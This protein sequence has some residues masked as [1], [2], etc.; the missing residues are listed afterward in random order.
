MRR[1]APVACL[2]ALFAVPLIGVTGCGGAGGSV[3]VVR[4]GDQAISKASVEHWMNVIARKG[5]FG[6]FRGEPTGTLKQRALGFL[7]SSYWLLGEATRQGTTASAQAVEEQLVGDGE[8]SAEFQ[9][10]LH[11]TG[12]TVADVK[13]ETSAEL[14]L[15]AIRA[16]LV[17]RASR[18]SP[19]QSEVVAYYR[20]HRSLFETPAARVTD[21]LEEQPS[22]AAAV[23]VGHRLGVG[24]RF[25]RAAFRERISLTALFLRTPE[26][27]RAIRRIFATRPGVLG[28]PVQ[29]NG[30]WIVFV[31]RRVIP[32]HRRPL[33]QVYPVVVGRM[34]GQRLRELTT[35]FDREFRAHWWARTSCRP[36]FIVQ[37]C[38]GSKRLLGRFEDPFAGGGL[39]AERQR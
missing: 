37:G 4:V 19:R 11:R 16:K 22:A 36:G 5:A 3:I 26:K 25:A 32:P 34:R 8:G 31:V 35:A 18:I 30:T 20:T 9:H 6:G 1:I 29:I 21:L 28:G 27:I 24:E 23:A 10:E 38:A 15:E 12:Q 13:L 14:A 39:A 17:N 2:W 7:I 33:A